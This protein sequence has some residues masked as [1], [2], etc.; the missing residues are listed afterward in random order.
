M[1]KIFISAL[2]LTLLSITSCHTDFEQDITDVVVTNGEADFSKYVALGNSLT[3][4]MRDGALYIDGQ[5][6]SYPAMLAQQMKLAGGGEFKQ[7][8]MADN[9][10]GI[11]AVNFKDKMVLVSNNGSLAPYQ[12]PVISGTTTLASIYAQGPY[13]NLGVPGAKVTHLLASGYGNPAGLDPT[14]LTA[15]PYFVRFA[16]S[17]TTS[18]LQDAL[19]QSPTFFS[20]WIGNND[21]LGYATTGGDGTNPITS[22]EVFTQAYTLLINGLTANGA[23]GV[24]A[25]LPDVTSIPNLT[26]V[27]YN[28]LTPDKFN[29]APAG[30]PSNQDANIDTINGSLYGPLKQVLTAFGAGNRI[31][32][33]ISKTSA[34]PLLIKDESLTNLAPQITAALTPSLGAQTA[35]AFGQIYGQARQATSADLVLLTTSA[36]IGTAAAG[37]PESINKYGISYPLQDQHVL[38]GKFA[39]TD[40]EVEECTAAVSAFN[41]IIKSL[42]EAKGL[43]FV[44][45]NAKLKE[46]NSQSGIQWDGVKYTAKFVTGGVFSLDGVHLTG[47]GYALIG[48]EFIKAINKTYKSTLPLV[49]PNQYSG[50]TFP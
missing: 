9:L 24:V 37:V 7:P 20:L 21:V 19:A 1:K 25:N 27:P 48:N 8:L 33:L 6:E 12:N 22:T 36:V 43:A 47:R 11:A 13:Q 35:A 18:V 50:V 15:N 45:A 41:G 2:A 23:K 29:T 32:D 5:N 46:L 31:P 44:D 34:N 3:S 40:G 30:S 38:R 28:P 26:T 42:A 49:N 16:S 10:G 4:G 14:N 17:A 39:G